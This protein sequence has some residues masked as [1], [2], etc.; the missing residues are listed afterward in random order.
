VSA[1]APLS[2]KEFNPKLFEPA[3]FVERGVNLPF[4]TP[5]LLGARARPQ[6]D[7][8]GL[9]V[10]IAN[11][12][13]ADGVYI[14]PWASIPQICTS[15]LH[16][17]RLWQLLRDQTSL[18]PRS[19]QD[20][21][22]T[23]ALEGL[24][25]R[26]PA[27]AVQEA[28]I[29]REARRKRINFGLLL[30]LI[31]RTEAPSASAPPPELDEPRKLMMRSQQAV[32]RCAA[33]LRTTT[34]TV[35][36]ALEELSHAFNGFG[37]P[38]DNQPAPAR[39]LLAEL[40]R[41]MQSVVGWREEFS[42]STTS[43]VTTLI[44][45]SL[46]LTLNCAVP[47]VEEF[48]ILISDTMAALE[49]WQR[50]DEDVSQR[51]TRIDWLL[52]GWDTI[53]G[54]WDTSPIQEK[55]NAI[56][57]MAMLAPILPKEVSDWN[58]LDASGMRQRQSARIVQ[59]F[60]DWRSGRL[61]DMIARNEE[62]MFARRKSLIRRST[63]RG[64]TTDVVPSKGPDRAVQNGAISSPSKPASGEKKTQLAETRHLMHA[65]AA[66]SDMALK[67]VVEI[68][69][70]L[71]DRLEADR[72]LD[73]ARPRLRQIRP[74]RSLQFTR[75][76]FLPLDGAIADNADWKRDDTRLP[77]AAL[78]G[79]AEA[80]RN[81]MGKDAE[82][83]E[84]SMVGRTFQDTGAVDRAGDLLWK[85]A[86]S[87]A[88]ELKPG[89]RWASSGLRQDDFAPL[90][91]L[92]A[93]VWRHAPGLWAAIKLAGWGP[94]DEAVRTA[95][96]PLAA[97]GT[98]ALAVGLAT[99]LQKA[100]SPGLVAMA[101]SSLS[102]QAG[103]IADAAL[104]EWLANARVT[105]PGED[106][107]AAA[108]LAETFGRAFQDLENAPPTRNPRRGERLIQLRQ[109]AEITCRLAY[110]DGLAEEILRKLPLLASAAT[111]EQVTALEGQ[112]RA[113]RR[114][115]LIGRRYGID[116]G[117]DG[118]AKRIVQA[119]NETKQHLTSLGLTKLDLARL[120]EILLGPEAALDLLA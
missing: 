4:T 80:L 93:S 58:G 9:E 23:V 113:L 96:T 59:Q 116:H 41:T 6:E 89:P 8:S 37:L 13:G 17:R 51:L 95:L 56:M 61:V 53:I 31:K 47:A 97:E 112:A 3:T 65:L 117:Y 49:A 42:D 85:R 119:L 104:D 110:E 111:P 15:T 55:A 44:L 2:F 73:A 90:V 98:T 76:L 75:L 88:P 100:T 12:S 7:G 102:D 71:P 108:S 32:A 106:L 63:M 52:D 35:A 109:E 99:L 105:L 27:D 107:V 120:G 66:A 39:H 64:K 57:E 36:A 19:V 24:A 43:P 114:I 21:A 45:Q 14:L 54:I 83:L 25:G 10:I 20:A 68:L 30:N 16:D 72:L 22:E 5:I 62:L 101:A 50:D 18:T 94:P 40:S 46:E 86:A 92:A 28:R 115:E 103:I 74:L 26:G 38:Q 118:A 69:D 81:A 84:A 1:R 70:R 82:V 91:K 78:T 11:P 77:R 79:I 48:D 87:L 29:A 33:Q 67:N 34:E 60:E